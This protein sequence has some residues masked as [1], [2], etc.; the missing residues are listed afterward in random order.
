[1]V[2]RV[3]RV[4]VKLVL[5]VRPIST[6]DCTLIHT[7]QFRHQSQSQDTKASHCT[8]CAVRMPHSHDMTVH[9]LLTLL[10]ARSGKV[11][12][13]AMLHV[14]LPSDFKAGFQSD[15]TQAPIAVLVEFPNF[16]NKSRFLLSSLSILFIYRAGSK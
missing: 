12:C 10:S 3:Y 7:A 1:M 13:C 16:K 9:C 15:A 14:C 2:S 5:L 4:R 11:P 8:H 6:P